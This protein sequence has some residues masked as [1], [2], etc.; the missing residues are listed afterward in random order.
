MA[1]KARQGLGMECATTPRTAGTVPHPEPS[2]KI[3]HPPHVN[4]WP[5][6]AAGLK[7]R[8][9]RQKDL[10]EHLRVSSPAVS[11]IKTGRIRLNAGQLTAICEF[12]CLDDAMTRALYGEIVEARLGRRGAA[13]L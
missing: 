6:I 9:L 7:A 2:E 1:R 8:G 11:Q 3:S 10:A 13:A 5:I 4:G 12:L